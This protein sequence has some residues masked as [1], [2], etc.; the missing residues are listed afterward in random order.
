MK[1]SHD[2]LVASHQANCES[3]ILVGHC[4]PAVY[5]TNKL[6]FIIFIRKSSLGSCP[7]FVIQN[8]VF[9]LII[10]CF[11]FMR[12]SQVLF[13]LF[14]IFFVPGIFRLIISFNNFSLSWSTVLSSSPTPRVE[15]FITFY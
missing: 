5:F 7:L 3:N 12:L 14:T 10:N 1:F 9:A 2:T 13:F 4:L 8:S 6:F 15:G 11:R